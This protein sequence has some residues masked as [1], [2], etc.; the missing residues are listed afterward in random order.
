MLTRSTERLA[1]TPQTTSAAVWNASQVAHAGQFDANARRLLVRGLTVVGLVGIALIHL[2]ELPDTWRES[3]GL[4]VMFLVLVIAAIAVAAALVHWDVTPLWQL[5]ALVALG[6]IVGYIVTR[7]ADLPFDHDDVGNWL[8]PSVLVATFIEVT[9]LAL[10][11]YALFATKE[12]ARR[13]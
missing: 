3:T 2:V 10:C 5:S 4:G 12:P 7:G 1:M 8:E 13:R 11:A 6:P 9:V